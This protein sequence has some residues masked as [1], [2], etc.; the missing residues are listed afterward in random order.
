[1]TEQ[2]ADI[3]FKLNNF[4]SLIMPT[5][6]ELTQRKTGHV[7]RSAQR[8]GVLARDARQVPGGADH[9]E[10]HGVQAKARVPAVSGP[11]PGNHSN[12][13]SALFK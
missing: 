3:L 2:K 5:F 1:M 6:E 7:Q 9:S 10:E 11:R 12:M 4:D 8:G 13:T